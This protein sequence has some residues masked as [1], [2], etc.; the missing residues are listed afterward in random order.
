MYKNLVESRQTYGH[1]VF[2]SLRKSLRKIC[3]NF[4]LFQLESEIG[5][6]RTSSG[7]AILCDA[8]VTN[9]SQIHS[10]TRAIFEI[11]Q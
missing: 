10:H 6:F 5:V 7:K 8:T 4:S 2:G 1:V 9:H 3:E 11:C